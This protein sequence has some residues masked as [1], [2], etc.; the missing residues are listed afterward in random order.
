M[1]HMTRARSL[2]DNTRDTQTNRMARAAYSASENQRIGF[3]WSH[4]ESLDIVHPRAPQASDPQ[5][6]GG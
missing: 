5:S 3:S 4:E 6:Q 2:C 1:A